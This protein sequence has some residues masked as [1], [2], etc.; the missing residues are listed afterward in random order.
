MIVKGQKINNRYEIIKLLGEGG[1]A[2]VYLAFDTILERKVAVK[3]LRGD[4]SSDDKFVRRFQREALAASSLSHPNIVEMYD[5][6][7][8]EGNFYIVMEYVE[9]K[10][11]KQLLKRRGILTITEVIDI[12]NQLTDGLSH[13]HDAYIIHRDIK[14]QNILILDNGLVKITD[15]GIAMALNNSQLTQTNSVM[16]S[17]HYLPPEQAAGR[18]STIKSDIY[19][20]GILM[21][22]LLVGRLPFKGEN[23]VEIALKHMRDP[24]P[25]LSRELDNVPQ[26]MENIVIKATAKNPKNRYN[27]A[28]EMHEDLRTALDETRKN[29]KRHVYKHLEHDLDDTKVMPVVKDEASIAKPIN[30]DEYKPNNKPFIILGSIFL[31]LIIMVVMFFLILPSLTKVPNVKIPDVSN[32]TTKEAEEKLIGLGFEVALEI[33]KINSDTIEEGKVVKTEPAIGRVVKKGTIITIYESIGSTYVEIEDYIGQDYITIKAA[34]LLKG[35]EV[36]EVKKEVDDVKAYRGKENLIIDQSVEV[37][38][39]LRIGDE[40]ILYIPNIYDVY[41]DM[42]KEEWTL[43]DVEIFVGEYDLLLNIEYRETLEIPPLRVISQ[44]RS[45]DSKIV[46]GASLRVVIAIA[47]VE[48]D[49]IEDDI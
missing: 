12:M 26:S 18:G 31:G 43:N 38:S 29:E 4:L 48:D 20:L 15:F 14:P 10:N 23:A 9:G 32:M 46:A 19:S 6:G 34:L 40:I 36:R 28:R 5:V 49:P 7:E 8:D 30:E 27:D 2:N 11:L 17:V 39:K 25:S 37:G 21:Y 47:P 35:L 13:A 44:N 3:I 24:I 41:P 45:P 1:M 16:G 22:E 33:E 42:V